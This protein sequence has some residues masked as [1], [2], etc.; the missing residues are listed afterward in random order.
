MLAKRQLLE[1]GQ[2]DTGIVEN[3]VIFYDRILNCS[4]YL[5]R[6]AG[7]AAPVLESYHSA[8]MNGGQFLI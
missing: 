3:I 8:I 5:E 1:H 2:L 7:V 4:K 6:T